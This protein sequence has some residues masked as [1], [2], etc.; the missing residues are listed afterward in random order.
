[1]KKL[2]L[3][4]FV[5]VAFLATAKTTRIGAPLPECDPC[6]YVR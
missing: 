4:A 1:M 5:A 2:M 3:L 6:P